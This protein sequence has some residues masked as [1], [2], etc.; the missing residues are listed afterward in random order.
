METIHLS[1]VHKLKPLKASGRLLWPALLEPRNGSLRARKTQ[2]T[3][4]FIGVSR[5]WDANPQPF[6]TKDHLYSYV[7]D[8]VKHLCN[9]QPVSKAAN[10]PQRMSL[11]P[12]RLL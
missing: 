5:P 4:P 8:L 6:F 3:S 2:S 10:L 1:R 7:L 12:R 11:E 9:A